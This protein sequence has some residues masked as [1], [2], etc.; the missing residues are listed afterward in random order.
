MVKQNTPHKAEAEKRVVVNAPVQRRGA[1]AKKSVVVIALMR[2]AVR[3]WLEGRHAL[4][5]PFIH[6]H[7]KLRHMKCIDLR[8]EERFAVEIPL[9]NMI[10]CMPGRGHLAGACPPGTSF[11]DRGGLILFQGTDAQLVPRQI[12]QRRLV[13]GARTAEGKRA[14]F[15][16]VD[17]DT[18][19][20]YAP[21]L[22]V[23]EIR[24]PGKRLVGLQF[25]WQFRAM[26]A[27]WVKQLAGSQWM[28]REAWIQ[29]EHLVIAPAFAG[30]VPKVDQEVV[31][32]L[33][34]D[35]WNAGPWWSEGE[36]WN[37][38]DTWEAPPLDFYRNMGSGASCSTRGC[39]YACTWGASTKA[40]C[41]TCMSSKGKK[42]GD[43]CHELVHKRKDFI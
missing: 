5:E 16:T 37:F 11:K 39:Q 10:P 23:P 13:R 41:R 12:V 2:S 6:Q 33:P 14:V 43:R 40:C 18:A 31:D 36:Y 38:F 27:K 4:G 34:H 26:R 17:F 7:L 30:A 21:V 25:V 15:G 22:P 24:G 20:L 8:E 1:E 29:L 32:P 19:C 3:W 28:C 9:C 35:W 42:H